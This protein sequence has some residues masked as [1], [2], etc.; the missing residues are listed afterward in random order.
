MV[1]NAIINFLLNIR[2]LAREKIVVC[3]GV[4]S[5]NTVGSDETPTLVGTGVPHRQRSQG[6]AVWTITADRQKGSVRSR[7]SQEEMGRKWK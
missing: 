3:N 2:A 7:I 4:V 6:G 1:K 5:C